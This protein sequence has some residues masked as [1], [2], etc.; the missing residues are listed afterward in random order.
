[1]R[2]PRLWRGVGGCGWRVC[3]RIPRLGRGWRFVAGRLFEAGERGRG[4]GDRFAGS[5]AWGES[6]P[7]AR[8]VSVVDGTGLPTID[9]YELK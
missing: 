1:M 7:V 3:R 2:S 6:S 9:S 4:G 8:I 5:E